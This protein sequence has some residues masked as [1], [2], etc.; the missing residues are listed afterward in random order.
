MTLTGLTYIFCTI[1]SRVASSGLLIISFLIIFANSSAQVSADLPS[2]GELKKLSLEELMNVEVISVS[3]RPEKLADVASAIQVITQDDIRRSSATSI[4]EA[5]RLA[6]NL[7]VAEHNSYAWSISSRGFNTTFSNKLLVMIDGR[8]VYNPLF[9]GVINI[10]TKKSKET[11][12]LYASMAAGSFWKSYAGVRYGGKIG[13]KI[14]YRVFG[15]YNDR[16]N[17]FLPDGRDTTD[18]WQVAHGGFHIDWDPSEKNSV[19]VQGNL[20]DGIEYENPRKVTF[21][22]QNIIAK[23]SHTASNTSSFNL[24]LYFDR[25]WRRNILGTVNNEL[26]T[27]DFDFHYN[28]L[29]ATNHTI[30]WGVGYRFMKDKTHSTT[31]TVGLI[32]ENK[33]MN[34]FSGFIQDEIMLVP[35]RFKLT[36]GT[37]LQHNVYSKFELQPN[38]RLAFTPTENQTVWAA[39]SRAVR[40]PS[41]AD[42]DYFLPTYPIP[43]QFQSVAGGPNFVSEKVVAY[44]LGY[45]ARPTSTLSF[46][47]ATFY[48]V[49][50]DVYSVE[51]L[52]NTLTYQIQN[53]SE[54]E[55]WGVEFSGVYQ[56]FPTWRMRGGYTFFDKDL[57]AKPGHNFDP[58]YLGNDPQNQFLWQSMVDLPANFQVDIIARYVDTLPKTQTTEHVPVY[59]TFDVRLAWEYND[60]EISLVGQNLLEKRHP[61]T[62]TQQM[63][64]C[65]YGKITFRL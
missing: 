9:G 59:G 18:A 41:R 43:P 45:R 4:P 36:L 26:D 54:G 11:Q 49:Y 65:V 42:V 52:P 10:I 30:S 8:T 5:L 25:T 16:N 7:H 15:Q 55:S 2:P 37:K 62:G 56:L 35:D 3:R 39:I 6:P 23:W 31:T 17:T 38:A 48:N 34:L 13:S 61:E 64:R 63:P 44:E 32:P 40:A 57:R 53:G 60:I 28:F 50:D 47:L 12:G 46:S 20:Y 19:S 58:T 1:G 21:D 24:Q 14:S 27:Y 29:L 22:G 51:A 33:D